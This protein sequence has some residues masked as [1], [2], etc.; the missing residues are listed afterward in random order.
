[1]ADPILMPKAGQTVTEAKIVEWRVKEGDALR[2]GDILFDMETD[3]AVTEAECHCDGVLLKI[4]VREGETVPVLTPVAM[5]GKAGEVLS[6]SPADAGT[7][8]PEI[9]RVSA[10]RETGPVQPGQEDTTSTPMS[11]MRQVIARRLTQ[12]YATTPHFFVTVNADMTDLRNTRKTLKESGHSYTVTDFILK[13]VV[14]S[15]KDFPAVNSVTTDGQTVT[16]HD[17]VHL[18]VA[19]ALEDGLVV[20]VIR[21]ADTLGLREL[22][23]AAADVVAQARNGRLKPDDMTDGTFTVSNMGMQSIENFTA[24]INPGEG[25]I[26]AI[27]SIVDSAVV[28]NGAV[29]SRAMMKMTLSSDHRIVDGTLAAK[30]LNAIK[31]RLED[32]DLWKTMVS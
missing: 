23:D 29:V 9:S 19:V 7:S 27:S 12:S 6:D 2:R 5:M 22:H 3:K 14:L 24:I 26:L 28:R 15:L 10:E 25:A 32:C 31:S 4:L 8:A 17:R 21:N 30:F 16:R 1:M 13:A 18:G 20:P 11:K